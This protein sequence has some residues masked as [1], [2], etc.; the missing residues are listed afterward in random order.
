[1]NTILEQIIETFKIIDVGKTIKKNVKVSLMEC[2]SNDKLKKYKE[3]YLLLND[4]LNVKYCTKTLKD[5]INI[6]IKNIKDT[7]INNTCI[8]IK[9]K[10]YCIYNEMYKYHGDD[11]YKLGNSGDVDK[12]IQG[13]TTSYITPVLILH[14]TDYIRNKVLAETILFD[15]LKEYRIVNNREFFKCNI[16]IIKKTMD[17]IVELFNKYTD[18]ELQYKY[19]CKTKRIIVKIDYIDNIINSK[20]ITE[21]Q[22]SILLKKEVNDKITDD[23]KYSIEKHIYKTKFNLKDED[24]TY[25]TLKKMYAKTHVVDNYNK[26]ISNNVHD[27]K[28]KWIKIIIDMLGFTIKDNQILNINIHRD[29]FNHNKIQ[30]I[31]KLDNEFKM[32]FKINKTISLHFNE[33]IQNNNKNTYTNHK[34]LGFINS[35]LKSY[36]MEIKAIQHSVRIKKKIKT[37]YTYTLKKTNII[38]NN[39]I[40]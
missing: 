35:L 9:G 3:L 39:N 4:I 36:G 8:P 12:R 20:N 29:N 33:L 34:F 11:V 23:E 28:L 22:V 1:M 18:D 2:K 14:Q 30:L 17:E 10:L 5:R 15:M 24:I 25:N 32:L 26:L 37:I 21:E 31:N 6:M 13:Y 27:S 19:I 7:Y 40:N 38:E 16:D